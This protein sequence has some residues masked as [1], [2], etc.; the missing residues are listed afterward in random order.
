MSRQ[1]TQAREGISATRGTEA[2][3]I[4]GAVVKL[5]EAEM[6]TKKFG[7]VLRPHFEIVGWDELTGDTNEMPPPVTSE[8]EFEDEIPF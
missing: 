4:L 3:N 8:D 1:L 6:P 5:T 7:K 2:E